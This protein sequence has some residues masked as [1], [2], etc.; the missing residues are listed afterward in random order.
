M[1]E[2]G[3]MESKPACVP[4]KVVL[5][6]NPGS[7]LKFFLICVLTRQPKICCPAPLPKSQEHSAD[8]G[9]CRGSRRHIQWL[10]RRF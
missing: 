10:S 7:V 4:M 1:D 8:L 2:S 5:D 6:G 3:V 9:T